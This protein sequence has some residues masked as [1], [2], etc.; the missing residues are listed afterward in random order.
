MKLALGTAQF[1][2]SYGIAN[3]NGQVDRDTA[4]AILS[5]ARSAGID[6]LDTA[7]AYGKSEQ[8]LGEIGVDNWNVVSK[9]PE[10]PES[11][12]DVSDWV[13]KQVHGSLSR[14]KVKSLKGLLLHSPGQLL[15]E[16]GEALWGAL[17]GIKLDGIVEK[18]GF[19]IYDPKDLDMFWN[20]FHPD[21]VQAPYNLLDHR[22]VSSGWLQ[23]MHDAGVEVH[24]RSVFLQGL[25]LMKKED[26]PEKFNRWLDLWN[27]WD[28]WLVEQRISPLQGCLASVMNDPRIGRVVVGVESVRQLEEIL[29]STNTR[30]IEMPRNLQSNDLDLITP[31]R[32][33]SF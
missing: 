11:C 21:I 19:S 32:W 3:R 16:Q 4:S 12:P 13:K 27:V 8:S 29:S 6:T 10:L 18:I 23:C 28:G 20:S 30:L 33:S 1:G 7:I 2:L 9:L 31:S 17:Q 26:R 15:N 5:R 14:L 22:L 24:V 25:L